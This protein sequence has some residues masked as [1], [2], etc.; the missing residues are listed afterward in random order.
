MN[1]TRPVA[2]SIRDRQLCDSSEASRIPQLAVGCTFQAIWLRILK[3]GLLLATALARLNERAGLANARIKLR[4]M[5][6]V[7]TAGGGPV[8][9]VAGGL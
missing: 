6:V 8:G 7:N 1:S 4:L 5:V 3:A 2:G 9:N